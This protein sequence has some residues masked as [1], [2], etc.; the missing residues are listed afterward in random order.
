[1]TLQ[2]QIARRRLRRKG[3]LGRI[4]A[5]MTASICV[6]IGMLSGLDPDVI[7]FRCFVGAVVVGMLVAFGVSV[8]DVANR[9]RE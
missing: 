2:N 4:S 3:P 9:P 5:L 8:I 1:M 7:L 6:P